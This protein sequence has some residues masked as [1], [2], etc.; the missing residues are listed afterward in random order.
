MVF[1]SFRLLFNSF[2]I[3]SR[4]RAQHPADGPG[5]PAGRR[6]RVPQRGSSSGLPRR[7]PRGW[8]GAPRRHAPR[9]A[10]RARPVAA[11]RPG[12][13]PVRRG[14]PGPG[15]RVA[16]LAA[17]PAALGGDANGARPGAHGRG[18]TGR[19]REGTAHPQ[20]RPV[21]DQPPSRGREKRPLPAA[22]GP[23]ARVVD[24]SGPGNGRCGG[25]FPGQQARTNP[26]VGWCKSLAGA[27]R[28]RHGAGRGEKA[29]GNRS[30]RAERGKYRPNIA[31]YRPENS[32]GGVRNPILTPF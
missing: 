13:A 15:P 24:A 17:G 30:G 1:N 4:H 9:G 8:A 19:L 20:P 32:P 12:R 7:G 16:G 22:V 31:K 10:G 23:E 21:I 5:P 2:L 14:G 18:C 26:L 28:G 29:G 3:R 6:G 11:A 25:P 27:C